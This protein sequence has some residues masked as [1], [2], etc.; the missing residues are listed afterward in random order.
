MLFPIVLCFDLQWWSL[1]GRSQVLRSSVLDN[2]VIR[3]VLLLL[4]LLMVVNMFLLLSGL[5]LS[6]IFK[7]WLVYISNWI[8]SRKL[9]VARWLSQ[10]VFDRSVPRYLSQLFV[11][12]LFLVSCHFSLF[13]LICSS[14]NLLQ[15]M[16]TYWKPLRLSVSTCTSVVNAVHWRVIH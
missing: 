14:P 11:F 13:P 3:S 9:K 10:S 7:A 15:T 6:C 5:C 1:L 4:F 8:L 12:S 16:Q 2:S